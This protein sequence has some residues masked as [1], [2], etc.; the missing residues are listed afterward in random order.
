MA[1]T[2]TFVK[3]KT[4]LVMAL[5]GES[6]EMETLT[7]TDFNIKFFDVAVTP[8]IESYVQEFVSGRHSKGPAVMGKRKVTFTAKASL[9]TSDSAAE[10][11]KIG[12]AFQACG[13]KRTPL[14]SPSRQVYTPDSTKDSGDDVTA[15]IWAVLWPSSG[16]GA[17]I[18]RGKGCMGNCVVSMDSLGSPLVAQFTFTGALV[19]VVD[20][21]AFAMSGEDTGTAPST[22][23]AVIEVGEERQQ[24]GKFSLD[25]GNVVELDSDPADPTG[26]AAA[27]IAKRNPKL[28]LNVKLKNLSGNDHYARWADGAQAAF[29]LT[30]AVNGHDLKYS[31]TAPRAQLLTMPM[32]AEEGSEMWQWDQ[33]YELHESTGNDEFAITMK[34]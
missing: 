30:T 26:Y 5:E 19:D 24:V 4:A 17:V 34:A 23:N 18:V 25:F 20:G 12:K 3:G 22:L 31:L 13:Q 32:A 7:S 11:P 16:T 29:E 6:G 15:T 1:A 14:T 21:T 28:M 10:A 8:E 2:P 9:L 27:Y 33:A